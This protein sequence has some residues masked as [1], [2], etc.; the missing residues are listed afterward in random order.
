MHNYLTE[1]IFRIILNKQYI[2]NKLEIEKI[3]FKCLECYLKK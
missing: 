2:L 1:M 3:A